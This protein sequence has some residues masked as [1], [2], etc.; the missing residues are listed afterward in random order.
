MT[1]SSNA[2]VLA[3]LAIVL[4]C[5][6]GLADDYRDLTQVKTVYILGMAHG[7]DQFLA[8]R[9]TNSGVFWVVLDP[10]NADAI[11]TDKLD[12]DFWRWLSQRFPRASTKS[13]P[14]ERQDDLRSG[15]LRG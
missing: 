13:A 9:L 6:P 4:L 2:R 15:T 10:A 11:V 12:E 14:A 8:N 1:G 3:V 5:R 7:L